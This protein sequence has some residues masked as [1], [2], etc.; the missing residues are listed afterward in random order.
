MSDQEFTARV[1][2][3][4]GAASGIGA[5]VSAAFCDRGAAVALVDVDAAALAAH[6]R[7]L[8]ARGATDV[9]DWPLDVTDRASISSMVSEVASRYHRIDFLVN[10]AASF[11][12]A[13]INATETQWEE[14]VRV[15]LIAASLLTAEV[16]RYMP[17]GSSVVNIASISA[18]VAQRDRWTYNA[19]KA[20]LVALTRGQAL[21]LGRL[22]IRVNAVSP[23]WIWTPEVERA[24]F[25]S[26]ET[27]EPVWGRFHILGRL[28]EPKEVAE[29]V[30]FL[31]SAGASFITGTEL[32]VDGGYS[33]L[34]PEGHGETA[35]FAGSA[36]D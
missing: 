25:G 6:A 16:S 35:S 13:G 27:W 26:R 22:G 4:T 30:V 29:A 20:A 14:A 11:I 3:I 32:M 33:A 36:S 12:S 18:H 24:A 9:T 15:N 19:T 23:G 17:A 1:A 28:G 21:D 5:A 8:R 10:S 2:I 31:S 34:G 7:A